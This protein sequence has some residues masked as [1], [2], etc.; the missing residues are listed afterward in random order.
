MTSL[1][2]FVFQYS[3]G[4]GAEV[5]LFLRAVWEFKKESHKQSFNGNPVFFKLS[6]FLSFFPILLFF[7]SFFLPF[8]FFL[9]YVQSTNMVDKDNFFAWPNFD[10]FYINLTVLKLSTSLS[11]CK[12]SFSIKPI[13][14]NIW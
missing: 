2:V 10:M 6:F 9:L 4:C 12:P 7:L 3:K 11:K 13:L 14:T 8:S 5:I 1:F